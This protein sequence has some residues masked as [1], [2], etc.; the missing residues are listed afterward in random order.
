MQV[1]IVTILAATATTTTTSILIIEANKIVELIILV[2]KPYTYICKWWCQVGTI[3]SIDEGFGVYVK[4]GC[5]T[6]C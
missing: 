2:T 3:G 4:S 5:I 6:D 1:L